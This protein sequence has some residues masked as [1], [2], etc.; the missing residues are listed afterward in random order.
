MHLNMSYW[1][2]HWKNETWPRKVEFKFRSHKSIHMKFPL[3]KQINGSMT[4]I[5]TFLTRD[6]KWNGN[7]FSSNEEDNDT[8]T[9]AEPM[10]S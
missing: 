2:I 4:K 5:F 9:S 1:N 10:D 6:P 8:V 3:E 7:S